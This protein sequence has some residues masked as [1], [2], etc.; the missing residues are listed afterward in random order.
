MNVFQFKTENLFLK[1]GGSVIS[2]STVHMIME[3]W[4]AAYGRS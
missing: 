1:K 3:R 4:W 2:I